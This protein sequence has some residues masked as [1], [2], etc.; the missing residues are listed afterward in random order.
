MKKGIFR[1][2]F[3]VLILG[4]ATLACNFNASTANIRDAFMSRDNAGLD[5][6][7]V[8]APE[9]VFYC[10]VEVAN[11][12]G[13]TTVKVVWYAVDVE[14]TE[15][16]LLIDEFEIT[17]GDAMLPFSLTS[18]SGIWPRGTYKVE[19]YLNGTLDRTLDFQVQ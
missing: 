11:A 6:T 19:L 7:T 18:N 15:P 10:I 13:D 3:A 2:V 16:N 1:I 9:D 12:P 14:N 17:T 5:P 4:L 8:F